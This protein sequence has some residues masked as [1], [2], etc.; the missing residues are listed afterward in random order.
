MADPIKLPEASQ[1]GGVYV[2]GGQAPQAI[3]VKIQ[4]S[5]QKGDTYEL[6]MPLEE[7][8]HLLDYLRQIEQR[9]PR[10]SP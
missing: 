1:M 3:H 4:Y 2:P 9:F 10:Q 8:M 5:D 6:Q 7:A